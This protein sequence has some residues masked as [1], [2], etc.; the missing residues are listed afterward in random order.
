MALF[1]RDERELKADSPTLRD[2]PAEETRH[3]R[4]EESPVAAEPAARRESGEVS[5]HLGKGSR[6]SGKLSFDGPV[7]IDGEV[8]GEIVAKDTLIV[9]EGAVVTAQIDGATII[10][11][12]TITGNVRASKRLELRAP[13]KVQGDIVTPALVIHEGARF[14]GRCSM[15]ESEPRSKER[16]PT[17]VVVAAQS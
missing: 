16:K 10:V 15:G 8:E 1:A 4:R 13:G 3:V 11:K 17:P 9:E 5:A 14:D 2:V 12:G 7:R 6:I